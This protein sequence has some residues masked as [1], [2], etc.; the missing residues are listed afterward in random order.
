M[1]VFLNAGDVFYQMIKL[2]KKK[3]RC[4]KIFVDGSTL[5]KSVRAVVYSER[6]SFQKV[7]LLTVTLT[8]H[9]QNTGF[10]GI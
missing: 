4:T 10:N 6:P 5:L 2:N 8:T 7:S 3:V 9:K 1:K